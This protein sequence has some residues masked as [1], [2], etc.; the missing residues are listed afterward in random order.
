MKT[1]KFKVGFLAILTA[2]FLTSCAKKTPQ[3]A[4]DCIKRTANAFMLQGTKLSSI[5]DLREPCKKILDLFEDDGPARAYI[6][7]CGN[8]VFTAIESKTLLPIEGE[9]IGD[10]DLFEFNNV[11]EYENFLKD[12]IKNANDEYKYLHSRIVIKNAY[13]I[14][15][16]DTKNRCE[17]SSGYIES[18]Y[19]SNEQSLS[20]FPPK[21]SLMIEDESL[22]NR[23]K[24]SLNFHYSNRIID[25]E[26][27]K[28]IPYIPGGSFEKVTHEVVKYQLLQD[29]VLER[30]QGP[31]TYYPDW[32]FKENVTKLENQCGLTNFRSDAK[33]GRYLF[34]RQDLDTRRAQLLYTQ[35]LEERYGGYYAL[36][37]GEI[38]GRLSKVSR[39]GASQI[40]I[41]DMNL[42]ELDFPKDIKGMSYD[43]DEII[44]FTEAIRN[45]P[46]ERS[47]Y[48]I[49]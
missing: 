49:Y 5:D 1:R 7:D 10:F 31:R 3:D 20:D 24:P 26:E 11:A 23:I 19:A 42:Q 13:I 15:E 36:N 18:I 16:N 21:I 37:K 6:T 30:I 44:E 14:T 35:S 46:R 41:I 22:L 47:P 40:K 28:T 45:E 34:L 25:V 4:C 9:D 8:E 17:T 32:N 43:I 29:G 48:S 33:N 27:E 39:F 2:V 38:I 12:K